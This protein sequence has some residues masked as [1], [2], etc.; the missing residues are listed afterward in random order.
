MYGRTA[1]ASVFVPYLYMCSIRKGYIWKFAILY[2][3][4]KLFDSFYDTGMYLRFFVHGPSEMRK[5]A[6]L[7]NEKSFAS[8]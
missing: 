6:S 4:L 1:L 2:S 7:D 8:I 3:F 5:V